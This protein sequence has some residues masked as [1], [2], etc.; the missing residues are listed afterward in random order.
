MKTALIAIIVI[1]MFLAGCAAKEI[2][3][4]DEN[5]P[6]AKTTT[7]K[8]TSTTTKSGTTTTKTTATADADTR[9]NTVTSDPSALGRESDEPARTVTADSGEDL[10][11]NK[12]TDYRRD[13]AVT[14]KCDLTYPLGCPKFLAKDGVVYITVKNVGYTSKIND[15]VVKL[16]G[17]ECDPVNSYIE[18]GNIKEF[19]CYVSAGSGDVVSGAL[20]VDYYSPIDQ[21]SFVKTGSIVVMME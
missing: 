15:V 16:D 12:L 8:T 3:S 14:E 1:F 5:Q 20:E 10:T 9:S 7:T 6:A 13:K 4:A 11:L 2:T 18:T 21:K 19:E 17:D